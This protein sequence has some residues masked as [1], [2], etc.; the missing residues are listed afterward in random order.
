MLV[1]TEGFVATIVNMTRFFYLQD[2]GGFTRTLTE[3]FLTRV[4]GEL[5]DQVRAEIIG[6]FL[7]RFPEATLH[8]TVGPDRVRNPD[9]ATMAINGQNGPAAESE[10]D[11]T[12]TVIEIDD[13]DD[14]EP[15]QPGYFG[16]TVAEMIRHEEFAYLGGAPRAPYVEQGTIEASEPVNLNHSTYKKLKK[17][18]FCT[19]LCIF[20]AN[21]EGHWSHLATLIFLL[22]VT[23][24]ILKMRQKKHHQLRMKSR[25]HHRQARSEMSD[26]YLEFF[27]IKNLFFLIQ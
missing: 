16:T 6:P 14:V 1:K 20:S 11:S 23:T 25:C 17:A 5:A 27:T 8:S 21:E 10:T 2:F 4:D 13:D 19:H 7:D 9:G 15:G 3:H 12:N 26:L 24:V 22:L 18:H